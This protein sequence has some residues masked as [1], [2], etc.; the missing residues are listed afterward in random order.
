MYYCTYCLCSS[1]VTTIEKQPITDWQKKIVVDSCL[2][3][4]KRRVWES[5]DSTATVVVKE[6]KKR[7]WSNS[8]S[9]WLKGVWKLINLQANKKTSSTHAVEY[10]NYIET[11][12][13]E[14]FG[15]FSKYLNLRCASTIFSLFFLYY[16]N[17]QRKTTISSCQRGQIHMKN[18]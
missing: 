12:L 5:V 2:L 3:L 15:K 11:K 8:W 10:L 1:N 6:M 16:L 17:W 4:P 13:L 9:S 14:E 7:L 18:N